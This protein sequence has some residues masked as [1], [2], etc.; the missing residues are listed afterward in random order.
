MTLMM[1]VFTLFYFFSAIGVALF[2]GYIF[3]DN[4]VLGPELKC[5]DFTKIPWDRDGQRCIDGQA[6]GT[7]HRSCAG[8]SPCAL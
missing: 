6:F 4:P 2:G 7:F 1:M 5:P 3:E 8:S